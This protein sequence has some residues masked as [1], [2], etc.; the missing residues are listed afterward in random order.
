MVVVVRDEVE[1]HCDS[2]KDNVTEEQIEREEDMVDSN[3]V[4]IDD[5][6]DDEHDCE[7]VDYND[8]QERNVDTVLLV[9]LVEQQA[10]HVPHS[11]HRDTF[12][13]GDGYVSSAH[14]LLVER[15]LQTDV[16]NERN[17]KSSV[18]SDVWK[19]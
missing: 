19:S 15:G 2:R 8:S 7:V 3:V 18:I 1:L 13:S 10:Q 14:Q 6:V 9:A 5:E 11:L 12:P 16:A 17:T 4:D